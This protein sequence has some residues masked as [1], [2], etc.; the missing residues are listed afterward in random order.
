M[1]GAPVTQDVMAHPNHAAHQ[2]KYDRAH[3]KQKRANGKKWR[4]ANPN[5]QREWDLKHPGRRRA[6]SRKYILKQYNMTEEEYNAR[7]KAQDGHCAFPGCL[8][9]EFRKEMGDSLAPDHNHE[10]GKVRDLLCY[11]HN[12]L[13][14]LAKDSI[15]ELEAA[16]SYLRKHQ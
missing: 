16:V 6:I 15:Q 11:R 4:K 14:G 3:K 9:T 1:S 2:R 5:Y 7:L 10:T 8:A 12:M 13:L